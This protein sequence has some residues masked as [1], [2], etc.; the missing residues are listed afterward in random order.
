[1][2]VLSYILSILGLLSMICASL[3]KG[4]NMKLILFFVFCGNVLVAT[5]YLVGG[6]G[7]NGAAACYLGGLQTLIN[8]FFESKNKPLPKWLIATYA[9]A[10]IV[11][12]I[13]VAKGISALGILVIVASLTF[14]LCIGQK[15]GAKYR[16]WTTV[17]MILWCIYDILSKSYSVLLTHIPQLTFTIV[18]T[19]IH[20]RKKNSAINL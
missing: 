6:S 4:K 15:N 13:W 18:G 12:N 8:Y 20:D 17:N 5:S 11:L 3:I 14:I 10:I 1:M 7:I 19:I 16:F 9:L 2:L